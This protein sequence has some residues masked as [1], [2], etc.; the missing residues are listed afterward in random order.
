MTTPIEQAQNLIDA[1]LYE[2]A[3]AKGLSEN[4]INAYRTD[5]S[6]FAVWSHEQHTDL[7]A[8]NQSLIYDYLSYCYKRGLS[9]TSTVRKLASLRCL[10]RHL[11]QKSLVA[12]NPLEGIK[13]PKT[14]HRLPDTISEA[15]VARLLLAPSTSDAIGLRD[16]AMLE[17]LYA[18]GL[19]VTE[20]VQLRMD[21]L[22]LPQG[23]VRV[24][25]KGQRERLVPIGLEAIKWVDE[26]IECAR[27][28][29][30]RKKTQSDD[31]FISRLGAQ[32]TRQTFWHNIKKHARKAGINKP[33]S[34]HVV[35][36]AFATHLINH[37]ADLRVV[38]MLLGHSSLNTTQIY[39]HVARARLQQQHRQYH[40]RG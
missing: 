8:V 12:D 25:G 13:N 10:Y 36:H 4:T 1:F 21:N 27:P 14:G 39:T 24:M 38:Q 5:L 17:L 30:L 37:D 22:N 33:I 29:L 2:H 34:P 28:E 35:R 19:R 23:V 18:C 9:A 7:L 15:E 16:R 11:C 31:V 26:Y 3:C 20:L 40:P 32:M 6:H